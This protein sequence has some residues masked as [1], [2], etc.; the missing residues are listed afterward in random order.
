VTNI[1]TIVVPDAAAIPVNH[2][3]SPVKVAGD[4]AYFAERSNASSLGYWNLALTQRAPLAGQTEKVYRSKISFAKPVVYSETINGITRPSLGYTLRTNIEFI[5][6]AEA[7]LQDRKDQRKLTVGI[8][9]DAS[10]IAMVET[11]DNLL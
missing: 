10:F 7:T 2:T 3:F 6:P 8:L 4:T 11:Q 5:V 9:N 1:T